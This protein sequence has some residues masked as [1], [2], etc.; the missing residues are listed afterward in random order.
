MRLGRGKIRDIRERLDE[1][2]LEGLAEVV[3]EDLE[4]VGCRALARAMVRRLTVE[5]IVLLIAEAERL[6]GGG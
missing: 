4:K 1:E 2:I 5:E 3:A 6:G